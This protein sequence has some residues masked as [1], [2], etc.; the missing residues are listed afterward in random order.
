M[1]FFEKC[2]CQ[3]FHRF[4]RP[5]RQIPPEGLELTSEFARVTCE[6]TKSAKDKS[7]EKYYFAKPLPLHRK[8]DR[9]MAKEKFWAESGLQDNA[10]IAAPSI[11]I[12]M[13]KSVSRNSMIRKMPETRKYLLENDFIDLKGMT[14]TSD[15]SIPDVFSMLTGLQ[16][17]ASVLRKSCYTFGKPIDH[18]PFIWKN[19]SEINYVTG[20]IEDAPGHS[21]FSSVSRFVKQ[22]T[23]YYGRPVGVAYM[24][25]G[26]GHGRQS[27]VGGITE[28]EL[29]LNYTLDFVKETQ[30]VPYFFLSVH[31]SIANLNLNTV[32]V[33]RVDITQH[34]TRISRFTD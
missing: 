2:V 7:Q 4:S 10:A 18:C 8:N 31:G 23:D 16:A 28:T 27:C 12:F 20:F 34:Y 9:T 32:G 1:I 30:H 24:K 6:F 22:P 13:I 26:V 19:F 17:S 15:Q 29:V 5:C 3:L 11:F 14:K 21:S 33:S 25:P